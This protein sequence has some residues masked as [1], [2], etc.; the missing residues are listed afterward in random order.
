MFPEPEGRWRASVANIIQPMTYF[1]RA[2]GARSRKFSVQ[3]LTVPIIE[4]VQYRIS[5]P[6]YTRQPAYEGP[7]PQGGLAGLPGALVQI[8]IRSNR[9]LSKLCHVFSGQTSEIRL[10]RMDAAAE[11]KVSGRL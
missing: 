8:T 6:E 2:R 10:I 11:T 1:V 5:A 7:L 3:V 4:E 9:P